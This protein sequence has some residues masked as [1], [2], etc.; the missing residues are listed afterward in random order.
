MLQVV[1][2]CR[3]Y[4]KHRKRWTYHVWSFDFLALW[5]ESSFSVQY[6]KCRRGVA[7]VELTA[8]RPKGAPSIPLPRMPKE[9]IL[10]KTVE[11]IRHEPIIAD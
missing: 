5:P 3:F 6:K 9:N 4:A 1:E 7:A 10:S 8:I 11:Y 2:K